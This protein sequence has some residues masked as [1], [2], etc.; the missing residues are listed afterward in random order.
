MISG[1]MVLGILGLLSWLLV[2]VC[3]GIL[4]IRKLLRYIRSTPESRER[5]TTVKRTLAESLKENRVQCNMTQEFVAEKIGVS[6]QAV[7]KRERGAS[8][9]STMNLIAIA[10]LYGIDA[11][12]LLRGVTALRE[13]GE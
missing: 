13:K 10:E 11:A 6:R 2:V 5:E 9:P 7:S 8:D 3:A 4:I 12:Q 1:W